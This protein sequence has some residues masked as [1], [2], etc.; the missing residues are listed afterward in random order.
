MNQKEQ[1][2]LA[3]VLR[4]AFRE[5]G[6]EPGREVEPSTTE[7]APDLWP[8]MRARIAEGQAPPQR[9]AWHWYFDFALAAAVPLWFWIF[10]QA[11]PGF[12]YHL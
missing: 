4:D 8:R 9:P 10:P 7:P 3:Q 6:R 1:E 5:P 11:L 12:F 2:R